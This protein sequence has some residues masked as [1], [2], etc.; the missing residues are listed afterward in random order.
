MNMYSASQSPPLGTPICGASTSAVS[1]EGW[2]WL[3]QGAYL[4][5]WV[6]QAPPVSC[7]ICCNWFDTAC[8]AWLAAELLVA[9]VS[10]V[11]KGVDVFPG[12][13]NWRSSAVGQ[14]TFIKPIGTTSLIMW[15]HFDKCPSGRTVG[16]KLFSILKS[17][18]YCFPCCLCIGSH[19]T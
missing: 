4:Q 15:Y 1:L 12:R 6:T 9:G 8:V 2:A 18:C 19:S 16:Q 11:W 5:C 3:S 17:A 10:E 13:I 14:M 7:C